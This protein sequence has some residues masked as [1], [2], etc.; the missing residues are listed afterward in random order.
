MRTADEREADFMTDLK[1]LLKRHGAELEVG[2]DGREYG[3]HQ[4]E[5]K[6]SMDSI[7]I[8]DELKADFHEFALPSWMG[9]K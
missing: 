1:L 4:G 2:D 5:V 8:D 9:G 7:W 3:M 6:I